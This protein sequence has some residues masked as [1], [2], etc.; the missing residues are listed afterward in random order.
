MQKLKLLSPVLLL[1]IVL[2]GCVSQT[3]TRLT[4]RT[5]TR[6]P[7]NYYPIEVQLDSTQQSMLW[8]T[9]QPTVL[10]GSQAY[11][12]SLTPMM[13]NRWQALVP[14]PRG[15]TTIDY[16]IKFDYM[17]NAWGTPPQQDSSLSKVYKLQIL[18]N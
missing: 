10:I 7:D 5:A 11:P 8:G 4:P 1:G 15:A 18:D 17:Y 12:M 6:S 3:I 2:T 14:I 16:R 13:T 9:I